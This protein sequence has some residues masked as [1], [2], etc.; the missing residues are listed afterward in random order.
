MAVRKINMTRGPLAWQII[1]YMVPLALTYILQLCFNAADLVIIG[2]FSSPDSVAAI[3]TTATVTGLF[4]NIFT[5]LSLGTNA[6]VAQLYGAKESRRVS[7]AAHTSIAIAIIAGIFVL[8]TG[9]LAAPHILRKIDV[10]AALMT[11]SVTYLSICFVGMPFLL[12]YNFGCAIL[13][14]VGDT[15]KPLWYL[16]IAGCIN[17]LLNMFL[18]IVAGMDVAGV[19]IATAISQAISAILVIRALTRAHG[20]IRIYLKFIRIDTA[21]LWRILLIGIPAGIQSACFAFSNLII[22]GAVN[23]FGALCMAANTIVLQLEWLIYSWLYALHQSAISFCGQN[24]G[25][26]KITRIT[27]TVILCVAYSL[28]I[29]TAMGVG[30]YFYARPL[31]GLFTT[32]LPQELMDFALTRMRYLFFCYGLLGIMDSLTGSL[33]GLGHS[34]F[35]MV[36]VIAGA[37]LFRI[38]WVKYIFADHRESF[39]LLMSSYPVSWFL[40]SAVCGIALYFILRRTG[41]ILPVK[42]S[43]SKNKVDGSDHA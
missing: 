1:A 5:G 13:R 18:V 25:A 6:V 29:S 10:P 8:V 37:C 38:W 2:R 11:K 20:A 34:I 39:G 9:L 7:Q 23:S 33:R 36:T 12:L 31:V 16:V 35:P 14:A 26:G 32:E 21:S 28:I 19:A 27:R 22:Q 40:V 3:G 43:P 17:V 24:L 4:V 15:R 41:E 42:M 30:M